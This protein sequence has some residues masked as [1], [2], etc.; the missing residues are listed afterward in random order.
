MRH[1]CQCS[2]EPQRGSLDE[3]GRFTSRADVRDATAQIIR[4][5][6]VVPHLLQPLAQTDHIIEREAE[7]FI[8]GDDILIG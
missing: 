6:V 1:Q 8:K 2:S 4:D 7:A 5:R 3:P